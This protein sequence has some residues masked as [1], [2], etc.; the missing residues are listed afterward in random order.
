[1]PIDIVTIKTVGPTNASMPFT[2]NAFLASLKYNISKAAKISMLPEKILRSAITS[3]DVSNAAS[4]CFIL[5]PSLVILTPPEQHTY[6]PLKQDERVRLYNHMHRLSI[7][8]VKKEF[9]AYQIKLS[10]IFCKNMLY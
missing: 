9:F 6:I 5:S 8:E 3:T 4:H 10:R 2:N 7:S 1:M